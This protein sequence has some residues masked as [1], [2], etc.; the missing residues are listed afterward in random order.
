M[1]IYTSVNIPVITYA[2]TFG[3]WVVATDNL[4]VQNNNF[5]SNNFLKPS[6]TLYLGDS[7]LGLQV[8]TAAI[9]AGYFQ[10]IGI[11]SSAFI[12]NNL[13]T[14][15]QLFLTNTTQGLY[16]SGR[17]NVLGTLFATNTGT[18]LYVTN[19]A[20]IG[21]ITTTTSSVVTGSQSING[22]QSV[23]GTTYVGTVQANS[24]ITTPALVVTSN[25][26]AYT[27]NAIF[28][29]ISA[30]G[31]FTI[32]GNFNVTGNTTYNSNQ[33]VLDTASGAPGNLSYYSVYRAARAN[34]SIRWNDSSGFWDI[35]D[36]TGSANTYYKIITEKQLAIEGGATT[37]TFRAAAAVYVDRVSVTANASFS[38]ANSA[39]NSIG[40]LGNNTRFNYTPSI[41]SFTNLSSITAPGQSLASLNAPSG[42]TIL[43]LT[44]TLSLNFS[45]SYFPTMTI[46]M[47][48][49]APY[50]S[51]FI[52]G[53]SDACGLAI[54]QTYG[55]TG[56]VQAGGTSGGISLLNINLRNTSNTT[57]GVFPNT[58]TL[59]YD[60]TVQL[61]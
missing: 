54:G 15:G 22:N 13:T 11:G 25:I 10:V 52:N 21:G 38:A 23:G 1:S 55:V 9:I 49:P 18:G 32:L 8:N 24:S 47:R 12:Q 29:N 59:F 34:A 44:G 30:I 31:S 20:I 4:I 37:G 58:E 16:N 33:F 17:A 26:S 53:S 36:T 42:A 51:N 27:A 48:V 5:T 56:T 14:N 46:Q 57:L 45:G 40:F 6:G 35:L 41:L 28:N 3:E 50:F 60:I 19:N 7:I 43:R 61:N 2:N 39:I